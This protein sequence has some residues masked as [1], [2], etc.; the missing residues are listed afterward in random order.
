MSG[1]PRAIAG[2][3]ALLATTAAVAFLAL[4]GGL[5]R[6]GVMAVP[7]NVAVVAHGP[8]FVCGVFVT[9]ISLERAVA[10][11]QAWGYL[12]PALAAGGALM[13]I[14]GVAAAPWLMLAA[15][16]WLGLVNAA[17]VRRQAALFTGLMLWGSVLLVLG[18]VG[19]VAGRPVFVVVVP[20]LAFFILTILAERLE[21][22]R[23]AP[24]PPW[25]TRALA[26][27]ALLFGLAAGAA[28][29]GSTVAAQATG[30]LLVLLALWQ[31]RFDI[32]RRT[33]RRRGLPRFVATGVLLG[34]MWLLVAGALLTAGPLPPAGPRYDAVVHAVLV[35]FVLS[36][37]FAH[38]PIILPAVARLEVPFHRALYAAV[39]VLHAGLALRIVGDLAG[40]VAWRQVGGVANALALVLFAATVIWARRRGVGRLGPTRPGDSPR[41]ACPPTAPA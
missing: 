19:W 35:G 40:I 20:W 26:A 14:F 17:I 8:L 22:S 41:P 12:G 24:T 10:L 13:L 5:A 7:V 27:L 28:M 9:V 31:L 2:R 33:L 32:A 37:V 34:A 3:R 30:V 29:A 16:A 39:L 1:G 18:T 21:L 11:G 6:L 36:M 15:S 23:L 38:A 4:L 25:A